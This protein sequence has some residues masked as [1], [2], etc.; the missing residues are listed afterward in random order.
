MEIEFEGTAA[1]SGIEV[2]RRFYQ[3][4][5]ASNG[6]FTRMANYTDEGEAFAATAS[7]GS[8]PI[9]HGERLALRG[10]R[11]GRDPAGPGAPNERLLRDGP[12]RRILEVAT[13]AGS[14]AAR[15]TPAGQPDVSLSIWEGLAIGAAVDEHGVPGSG[16][17]ERRLV[18]SPSWT[19]GAWA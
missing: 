15:R 8:D 4:A 17:V 9:V 16:G 14:G 13:F 11:A 12:R 7:R 3:I 1:S 10:P 5:Q 6:R 2:R 19:C 18:D